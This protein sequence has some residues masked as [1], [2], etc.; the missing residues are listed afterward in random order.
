VK[1]IREA[2]Y[3]W[4]ARNRLIP[5]QIWF[6]VIGFAAIIVILCFIPWNR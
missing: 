2:F 1:A 4:A 6:M 3:D 5:S